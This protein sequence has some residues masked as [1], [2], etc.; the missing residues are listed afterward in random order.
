MEL[1]FCRLAELFFPWLHSWAATP[2]TVSCHGPSRRHSPLLA[3]CHQS[4]SF[5]CHHRFS[6][7]FPKK[8]MSFS[9]TR[10]PQPYLLILPNFSNQTNSA[11]ISHL[12]TFVFVLPKLFSLVEISYFPLVALTFKSHLFYQ[13]FLE[14]TRTVFPL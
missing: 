11:K 12:F 2:E 13:T 1:P 3:I 10:P 5:L 14:I 4:C 7:P 6:P 9:M 8:T